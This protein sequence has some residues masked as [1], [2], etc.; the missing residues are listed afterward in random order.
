MDPNE[1]TQRLLHLDTFHEVKRKRDKRKENM[2]S[3]PAEE[4]RGKPGYQGRGNRGPRG[5]SYSQYSS[6]DAGGRR[7][8]AMRK[9]NGLGESREKGFRR[10]PVPVSN[11]TDPVK[12]L[13]VEKL[14]SITM[15]GPLKVPNGSLSGAH[16]A[17]SFGVGD[18]YLSKDDTD[19]N[20]DNSSSIPKGSA[21]HAPSASDPVLVPS[22]DSWIPSAV[23][24]IK[25]EVCIQQIYAERSEPVHTDGGM[26]TIESINN[27]HLNKNE[28]QNVNKSEVSSAIVEEEAFGH[29]NAAQPKILSQCRAAENIHPP[30]SISVVNSSSPQGVEEAT[31]KIEKLKFSD[32]KHVIIPNHIQVPD[33]VKNVLSFGSLDASFGVRENH[34]NSERKKNS[35]PAA[36]LAHDETTSKPSS[37]DQDAVSTLPEGNHV[38]Q[39]QSPAHSPGKSSPSESKFSPSV[40]VPKDEQL[41]EETLPAVGPPFP[42]V[43]ATPS[44]SFGFMPPMLINPPV[45]PEGF[46]SQVHVSNSLTENSL[47]MSTSS[48]TPPP[49]QSIGAGQNSVAVSPPPVALFRQPYPPNYVP[50]GHYF[51]PYYVPPTMHQ[52]FGHTAFAPPLPPGNMYLTPPAA[53]A[54]MK[55]S[56]TPY[57]PGA[58]TGNQ[59]PVGVPSG[60]GAYGSSQVGFNP[61]ASVTSGNSSST[62]DLV[63]SSLKENNVYPGQQGEGSTVWFPAA[64]PGR[65]AA[66]FPLNSFLNLAPQGHVI[67]PQSGPG[68]FIYHTLHPMGSPPPGLTLLQQS[69]SQ[70]MAGSVESVGPPP[71]TYQQPVNWNM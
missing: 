41:K 21:E 42:V 60:Y 52:Y 45:Q 2:N 50:Y 53:A 58:N 24:A 67:P 9:E 44:Y 43:Q 26:G 13:H 51:S 27:I 54:G 11:E 65:D 34:V 19:A 17:P 18:A 64:G 68:A 57:K 12:P 1:T 49:A 8:A 39:P 7:N 69:H 22:R 71:N 23:G 28:P 5:S 38:D 63:P 30:D 14:S 66:S 16:D 10:S 15:N 61:N 40:A 55:I 70:P 25:R 48:S 3:R 37:C 36:D 35:N 32:G 20:A 29:V 62:E 46:E 56:P 47:A 4:F 33:A 6:N 59:A 31:S